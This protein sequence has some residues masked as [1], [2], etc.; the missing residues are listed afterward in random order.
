MTCVSD[1]LG[2][3]EG[4]AGLSS[5]WC[6]LEIL[7]AV[8]TRGFA[9][10]FV[11]CPTIHGQSW[12]RWDNG[13]IRVPLLLLYITFSSLLPLSSVKS[14]NVPAQEV[15]T[16]KTQCSFPLVDFHR[17]MFFN[18]WYPAGGIVLEGWKDLEPLGGG[19]LL[20]EVGHWRRDLR[21]C[22]PVQLPGC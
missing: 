20:E 14:P 8:R 16:V 19:T 2:F 18:T 17:L 15:H 10:P 22:S 12:S 5:H 7:N 4:K 3:V 6:H 13:G 9:C 11:V 21:I 1:P